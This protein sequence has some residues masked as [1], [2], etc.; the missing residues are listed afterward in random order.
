MT[1]YNLQQTVEVWQ[2]LHGLHGDLRNVHKHLNVTEGRQQ[3]SQSIKYS[4]FSSDPKKQC[5]CLL[6]ELLSSTEWCPGSLTSSWRPKTYCQTT[7]QATANGTQ[8]TRPCGEY[9]R[10]SWRQMTDSKW[11]WSDCWIYSSEFHRVDHDLLQRLHHQ[12]SLSDKVLQWLT[13]FVSSRTQQVAYN[14]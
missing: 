1:S 13:S 2:F 14:G 5:L 7:S 10:T 8:R 6:Y 12:F 3:W 9:C 4:T 11:R